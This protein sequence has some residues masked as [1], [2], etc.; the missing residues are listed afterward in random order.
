[1]RSSKLYGPIQTF[2]VCVRRFTICHVVALSC[3]ILRCT[4]RKLHSHNILTCDFSARIAQNLCPNL[5]TSLRSVQHLT[6]IYNPPQVH[7][8]HTLANIPQRQIGSLSHHVFST[9]NLLLLSLFILMG[10]YYNPYHSYGSYHHRSHYRPHRSRYHYHSSL[11]KR[12]ARL[13]RRGLR[14]SDSRYMHGS[15]SYR[16]RSPRRYSRY[17]RSYHQFF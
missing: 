16:Y 8:A 6:R 7:R 10:A 15:R 4:S 12:L 17:H 5:C 3:L 13:I 14:R 9:C 11:S 1:M 2:S